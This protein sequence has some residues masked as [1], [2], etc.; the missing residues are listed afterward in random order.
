[1]KHR[2]LMIIALLTV[3]CNS[4]DDR[5]ARFAQEATSQQAQQNRDMAHLSQAVTEDHRRVVE[6]VEQSRQA[7]VDLEQDLQGQR[8]RLDQERQ[9]LANERYRESLLGPVVNRL[10][11]LLVAALPLVLCWWLL[12]GLKSEKE[13]TEDAVSEFLIHELAANES[14]LLPA[15]QRREAIA[16]EEA[17]TEAETT[18]TPPY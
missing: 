6:T 10:G 3:G 5:L 9:A 16:H 1:M 15:P 2:L 4:P 17:S 12:V 13:N 8:D 11:M 18:E 14:P 7:I